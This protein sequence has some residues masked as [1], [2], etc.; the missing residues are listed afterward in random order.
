MQ[1]QTRQSPFRPQFR[2][3]L[4][5]QTA[6]TLL[7]AIVAIASLI[8]EYGGFELSAAMIRLL[9]TCQGTVIGVFLVDRALRI[10]YAQRPVE[11]LRH[12]VV[13]FSLL[14][15]FAL[16]MVM[17][18]LIRAQIPSAVSHLG[19]F[20]VVL[21]Q[22][23][24]LG[25]LLLRAISWNMALT[26]SSIP[27]AGLLVGS[28]AALILAG[29]GLLMLPAATPTD[30][31][32]SWAD[33]LF[34]SVSATCVTGLI[35]RDTGSAFTTF[36][37]AVILLQIQLGALGIMLFGTAVAMALGRGRLSS[38]GTQTMGEMLLVDQPGRVR[39]VM[40][41]VVLFTLAVEL[42]GAALLFPAF[43]DRGSVRWALGQSVFHS[44]SAFGNAGFSLSSDN[45]E[46][47]R[48]TWQILGVFAPLIILGGIGFPALYDLVRYVRD[49]VRGSWRPASL[50]SVTS[51]PQPRLRLSLHTKLVLA[52][53]GILLV[54]GPVGLL[55]ADMTIPPGSLAEHA[56]MSWPGRTQAAIFQ[57]IS[58][59]TAGFNT[60]D[61]GQLSP[62]GKIWMCVL[63]FIGGSP[64]STAGGLKT[65][66]MA[67]VIMG[68]VATIR[69]RDQVTIF[70][71]S[72]PEG[73]LRRASAMAA[74][75][76]CL[77]IGVATVLVAQLGY[78]FSGIDL[79]FEATS[80]CGTVGLSTDVTPH[81]PLASKLVV[82][83]GMFAGRVGPLTLLVA[84][85]GRTKRIEYSYPDENVLIG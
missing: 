48:G 61:V 55:L 33:A 5:V 26:G 73:I 72:I 85:S 64:A 53:T 13:D 77:V 17:L 58:A 84:L 63:M 8:L 16:G 51:T 21:M 34:T 31:P 20:Y 1:R 32:I 44:I 3:V 7:A 54:V 19:V 6:V 45:L 46:S 37:Q 68:T 28:F 39:R 67:L 71:R 10:H 40:S 81:L 35:V 66:T 30:A 60:V 24:L 18:P 11:Y 42:L 23:Y 59:R 9:H 36:G 47:Y 14:A 56:T 62:V 82:T 78:R 41:F 2:L 79:F 27:P 57:S 83:A 80:A 43:Q 4:R 74:L 76:L 65:V 12:H 38:R 22:G 69:Q 52:V 50:L 29:T 70:G 75:Y 15:V 49:K 25:T